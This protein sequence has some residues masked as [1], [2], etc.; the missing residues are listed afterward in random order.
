MRFSKNCNGSVAAS[1]A[2]TEPAKKQG[3]VRIGRRSFIA[4]TNLYEISLVMGNMTNYIGT[5]S[6]TV[7]A[8][9][10]LICAMKWKTLVWFT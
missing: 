5:H 9:N 10:L 1:L 7:F 3:N 8:S 6:D 2:D 4:V